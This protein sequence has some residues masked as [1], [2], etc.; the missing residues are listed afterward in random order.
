M[1]IDMKIEMTTINI[2]IERIRTISFHTDGKPF[3]HIIDVNGMTHRY[4]GD[5]LE[6]CNIELN[7]G[8]IE[9]HGYK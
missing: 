4:D 1:E 6:W 5:Q 3:V 9:I 2:N 8:V 7:D